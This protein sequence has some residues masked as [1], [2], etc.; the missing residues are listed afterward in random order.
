MNNSNDLA[1]A[2][3]EIEALALRGSAV[4]V[5]EIGGR[6]YLFGC[7]AAGEV[8]C[9]EIIEHDL[10]AYPNCMRVNTLDAFVGY[11]KAGLENGE[12]TDKIYLN[13]TSPVSVDAETPVNKYGRRKQIAHA[14]R[15]S[16]RG[17][18]FGDQYDF[19]NFVVALRSKFVPSAEQKLLLESLKQIT[20][21]NEV[22]TEDNGITQVVTARAGAALG[23]VNV[24]PIWCLRPYRTFTEIEQPESLFLLRLHSDGAETS[25]RL[26]ETDGGAWAVTAMNDVR[27]YLRAEFGGEEYVGKVFVL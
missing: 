7:N 27:D 8:S 3:R 4:Q 10:T 26:Y 16:L 5:K 9:S 17:F 12:I 24:Q 13:V 18:S 14:E 22:K 21:S 11:I 20:N 6:N 1:G 19:E 2:I 25:Y 15:I 23:A